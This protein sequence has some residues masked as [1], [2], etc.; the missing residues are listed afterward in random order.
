MTI[1]KTIIDG[2]NSQQHEQESEALHSRLTSNYKMRVKQ[3]ENRHLATVQFA[4]E[5]TLPLSK[6]I[7]A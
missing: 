2:I 7:D 5:Q 6:V 1:S 3:T 4:Y